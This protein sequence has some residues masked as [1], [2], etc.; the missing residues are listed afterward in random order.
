MSIL[1]KLAAAKALIEA[2]IEEEIARSAPPPA[3]AREGQSDSKHGD[4]QEITGAGSTI[5]CFAGVDCGGTWEVS[6]AR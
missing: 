4:S 5:A 3:P 1:E 2:A 6:D